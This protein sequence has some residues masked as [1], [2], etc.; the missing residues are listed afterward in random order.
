MLDKM[1]NA[2][3][4]LAQ[5]MINPSQL[6]QDLFLSRLS[7][8]QTFDNEAQSYIDEG[9]KKNPVFRAIVGLTILAA[10]GAKWSLKDFHHKPYVN[11]N[12]ITTMQ[13]PSIGKSFRDLQLDTYAQLLISGNGFVGMS[14]FNSQS[15]SLAGLPMELFMMPSA[16]IQAYF[17]EG[18]KGIEKY[19]L[20]FTG[21][22]AD[23]S[24]G[25]TA[26]DVLHL[27]L[28]TNPDYSIEGDFLWASAPAE[29]ARTSIQTYNDTLEA[30]LWYQ[31]NK[32][33]ES[34]LVNA[35]EDIEFGEDV[36][37]Q[38]KS[39]LRLQGQG[40]KNAGNIPVVDAHLKAVNVGS[41]PE[42]IKLLPLR[43]QAAKEICSVF[44]F[45]AKLIGIDDS[46]YQNAKE[47]KKAFWE[48]C[49]IPLLDTF[50]EGLNRWLP[51]EYGG[52]FY[53]DYD[54]SHVNALQEDLLTRGE[55]ISK[56]AGFITINEAR[57]KAGMM[58]FDFMSEPKTME[59]FKETMYLGFTQAVVSDQEEISP[60]NG[61]TKEEDKDE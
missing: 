44:N 10:S 19:L 50:K 3:R 23:P 18:N 43:I 32:G 49:V 27:R 13:R 58:P 17:K 20:D 31:Q 15:G 52:G 46:T 29:A 28:G 37:N 11:Q 25:V 2:N 54:L 33:I 60:T 6:Y 41:T 12:L 36:I 14:R 55:A 59:E 48:N 39:S 34:I 61:E 45:P 9:W 30:G 7:N 21:V 22:D 24:N 16:D 47:A 35:S 53:I 26:S 38:L 1:Y 8:V 51:Q 40:P 56:F 4:K 42:D 57:E 5:G